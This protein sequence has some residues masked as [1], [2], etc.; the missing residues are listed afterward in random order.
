MTKIW[1]DREYTEME[2]EAIDW[3]KNTDTMQFSKMELLTMFAQHWIVK[4]SLVDVSGSISAGD[5]ALALLDWM[6]SDDCWVT[7]KEGNKL[8]DAIIDGKDVAKYAKKY[9]R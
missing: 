7:D 1:R 2:E 9:Y 5:M 8:P 3:L 4:S 6:K